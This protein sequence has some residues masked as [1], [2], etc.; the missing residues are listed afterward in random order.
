MSST[1]LDSLTQLR[2]SESVDAIGGEFALRAEFSQSLSAFA[3]CT[4]QKTEDTESKERLSNSPT[5]MIKVGIWSAFLRHFSGSAILRYE[6][7]RMTVYDTKTGSFLLADLQLA[8][9]PKFADA[10][11]A[12][13]VLNKF[14]LA[15][16]VRNAF[17]ES[18]SNPGGF[19]HVQDAIPQDG[20]TFQ[21]KLT[22]NCRTSRRKRSGFD[23][24]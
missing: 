1:L 15:L 9:Q 24:R 23:N 8:A 11:G 5:T 22:Y 21:V 2:N 17:N 3:N 18:Y 7:E 20:R 12:G 13:A 16:V 14:R 6:S 4:V 10:S 19:E